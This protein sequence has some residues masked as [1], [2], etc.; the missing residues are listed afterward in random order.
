VQPGISVP[1]GAIDVVVS[2][3][4]EVQVKTADS[5]DL[6]TVGQIQ[7]ATFI[8]DAGLEA[9]GDNLFLETGASG[10]ANLASPG[11]PGFGTVTQG[12]VEASNVNPVEEITSL[13]SAQRAY[14]MNSRVVKTVDEMLSTA[15]QLR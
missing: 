8:N 6:Q 15:S 10:Q 2:K 12:F 14:E 13:I 11:E 5:P 4:G 1:Q 9:M 7:L 3:T